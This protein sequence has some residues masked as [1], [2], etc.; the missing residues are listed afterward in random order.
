MKDV[1]DRAF[2]KKISSIGLPIA[3][4]FFITSA[5]N[6]IDVVMLG[7][8][9]EDAVAASGAVNQ[10][11]F[12][13][14]LVCFGINSGASVFLSQFWGT[15]DLRNVR[16]TV[17]MMYLLGLIGAVIFTVAACV[18][19]RQLVSLYVHEP[20]VIKLAEDYLAIIAFTFIVSAA[21]FALSTACRCTGNVRLPMRA[22]FLAILVNVVGNSLLIFGLLGFPALGV[23]GAAIATAISRAA[24][25]LM[26]VLTVYRHKLPPAAT[27]R[28]LFAFDRPFLRH[29]VRTTWPVL[30]NETLWSV[31][32]SLYS[33]AF[34]Q[35]GT[36]ALA[37]VQISN[38]I[39]QLLTVFSRGFSNATGIIIG[40]QIGAGE[41]EEA[42]HTA[43]RILWLMPLMGAVICAV[44]IAVSPLFL[45]L[46]NVS[47]ETLTLAREVIVVQS[48]GMILKSLTM[49]LIVGICRSGGDTLFACVAD[50]GSV[51]LGGVPMGFLGVWLGL[52]LWGVSVCVLAEEVLKIAVAL[53]RVLSG[54][55]VRNVAAALQK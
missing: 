34:G 30:L 35:L 13:L 21:S 7:R 37:A 3:A 5:V 39:V 42:K 36:A 52:P 47:A 16:R 4:Q 1:F 43:R 40:N 14:N 46:Y 38:T 23:R 26:L 10:I 55:W 12:I 49:V 22:S 19:P 53:P 17:G 50:V 45:L 2:L 28:E 33:V 44:T 8:L 54:K 6:L 18:I 27:L 32:V 20:Q 31:G 41:E 15:R 11:F 24:E 48:A 25:F 29:Y 9:G 51:W